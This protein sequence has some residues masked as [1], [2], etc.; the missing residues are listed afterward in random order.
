MICWLLLQILQVLQNKEFFQRYMHVNVEVSLFITSDSPFLGRGPIR[1][2]AIIVNYWE[3]EKVKMKTMSLES[4]S[5]FLFYH[6][7]SS[8]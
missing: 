6:R 7:V 8:Y 1:I 4:Y 3:G 5:L 2:P